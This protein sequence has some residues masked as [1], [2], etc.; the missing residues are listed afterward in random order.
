LG[1][2]VPLSEMVTGKVLT[3][4]SRRGR[5]RTPIDV[6]CSGTIR[7]RDRNCHFGVIS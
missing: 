4:I 3:A 2:F 7:I 1:V 5:H 6:K